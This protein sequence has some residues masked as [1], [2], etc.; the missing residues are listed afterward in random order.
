MLRRLAGLSAAIA[1]PM[2]LLA[3]LVQTTQSR[4]SSPSIAPYDVII[5]EWSQGNGGAK[6]WVEL[7]VVNGPVDLRG[8]NLGDDT[9]GDLTFAQVPFWQNVSAGSLIV[10]YNQSDRD[11]GLPP[12]DVN[13]SDCSAILPDGNPLYFSGSLPA[14]D[15]N[16]ITDN[17]HLRDAGGNTVH[18]FSAAPGPGL[19]PDV[20]QNAQFDGTSAAGVAIASNWSN[21]IASLA[22]PAL[23]NGEGNSAWITE[24]CLNSRQPDLA[25]AKSGPPVITAGE[26]LTYLL[27]VS[28]QGTLTASGVLL[29]DTLPLE[30]TYI[31]QDSGYPLSQP[32]STTLVWDLGRL[33]A[34]S[35]ISFNLTLSVPL[36]TSGIVTN[37]LRA[38]T[39]V[40]ELN[41]LNNR[42]AATTTVVGANVIPLVV[43]DAV[44]YDGYESGHAD[45]A[46]RLLNLGE[47]IADLG[48]W[49]VTD[50]ESAVALLPPNAGLAPGEAIWLTS[51]GSAF[52]RQFGFLPDFELIDAFTLT[53]P[54]LSGS[55]PQLAD[56]G[57]QVILL[58]SGANVIDCLIYESGSITDCGA[59]W[60]GPAVQPYVVRSVLAED[61]QI[62]YRRRDQE[63]GLPVPDT[64]TLNDWAQMTADVIDGRKT[65][66]P[67]WN[68]ESFFFTTRV[69]E[70]ATLTVA[71]A[72]DNAYDAVVNQIKAAR[73]TI[74]IET[75]TI[76][77]VAIGNALVDAANHNVSVTVLM[78]GDPFG[79]IASREKY[80]CQ[81]LELAGGQCWFMISDSGQALHD[82]YSYLH[83]KFILVDGQRALISSENLSPNSMPDDD[84][85]DGTW[86]RRGVV[87]ITDSPGVVGRVKAIFEHDFAPTLHQDLY[88]WQAGDPTYGAPP[89][90][91]VPVTITGGTTYT[92]RYPTAIEFEGTQSF[93]V[94]HS[95]E[96][97]LRDQDG[98]LGLVNKA[99]LGDTILVQQLT[100]RPYWGSSTSDP[101]ADP[102][103]R[104]EA[105]VD[106]ARRG[107][108]V[109]L[110]LD[111]LY[112]DESDPASNSAT[113][114]YVN[115]IARNEGLSLECALANPAG[116]GIHN[117]M[118]LAHVDGRGFVHVGSINGTELSSKGNRELALQVQSDGAYALLAEMFD[119]D[120]PYRLFLPLTLSKYVAPADHLLLSEFLYDPPG[121]DDGE[122]IEIVNPTGRSLDLS[123][124]S[125]GDA[126]N[127]TDFEDVRRFPPGTT[128]AP[129]STLVVAASAIAFRLEYGFAPDFEILATD[130]LVPDLID[131]LAWGDPAA[132]LQLGNVGDEIILRDAADLPVDAVA[133]GVGH[134]PGVVSCE[135]TVIA[136]ATFERFPYWRDTDNCQADFREWPFPNPGSLP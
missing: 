17:P 35:Q 85:S 10:I 66:Y 80:I 12:D 41:Q 82:R 103:P 46:V 38:S 108:S 101:S 55:W 5:N 49:G 130:P 100:E 37:Q 93:E 110:L 7:L 105:Y 123:H 99:S 127:R 64:D 21:S 88:R 9:A 29:T 4:A 77:N 119:R 79:S 16:T 51:D 76:E 14:F 73:A 60:S 113:C 91:Y 39:A 25:V 109:R 70:S 111:S 135:L 125:L 48:G 53:V 95:P 26:P 42:A 18:D 115:S 69:T 78:E 134:Y 27:Q 102:N 121:L 13:L 129:G 20:Q 57:D 126:V 8:W 33:A 97:S 24:L 59:A 62:L 30:M 65:R 15:N 98:L 68:L 106:A 2:L 104:L 40:T 116:L 86:G 118:V 107:A 74:Q 83:A 31:S 112:D 117:K 131:D 22:S 72:P 96:N 54:N 1:L 84:K 128:I 124:Y 114:D 3:A 43:I 23:G 94:I 63:T 34:A 89:P 45:E 32:L 71:V 47:S 50:G 136:N 92:T 87:L 90:G 75:L 36:G 132:V 81:R 67:G 133:Y 28:N 44:L 122:F 56:S 52:A 58:D 6:E 11:V 61:G 120:W 19:H